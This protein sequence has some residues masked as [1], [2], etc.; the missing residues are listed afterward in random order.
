MYLNMALHA[1]DASNFEGQSDESLSECGGDSSEE[2]GD[3]IDDN[4]LG[5]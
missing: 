1:H 4:F 3:E 2:I 5:K